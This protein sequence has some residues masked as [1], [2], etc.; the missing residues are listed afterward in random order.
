MVVVCLCF[1][2]PEVLF[3][4]QSASYAVRLIR[5]MV[6]SDGNHENAGNFL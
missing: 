4:W 5:C 1:S 2:F 3:L 6:F